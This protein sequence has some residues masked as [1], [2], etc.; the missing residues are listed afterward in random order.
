[1]DGWYGMISSYNT[2]FT[3]DQFSNNYASVNFC[4]VCDDSFADLTWTKLLTIFLITL[5]I[6]VIAVVLFWTLCHCCMCRHDPNC[7]CKNPG[8][9]VGSRQSIS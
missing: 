4:T 6:L 1:V 2:W 7:I 9:K 5:G 3:G 8:L